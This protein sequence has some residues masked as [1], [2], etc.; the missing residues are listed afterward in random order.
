MKGRDA[1]KEKNSICWL[2]HQ[3]PATAGDRPKVGLVQI[4]QT[5]AG[6]QLPE[7]SPLPALAGSW[8][9]EMELGVTA[10]T[11]RAFFYYVKCLLSFLKILF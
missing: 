7:S 3:V 2:T 1:D 6:A 8:S 4:F 11:L 9:A 10:P 5:V